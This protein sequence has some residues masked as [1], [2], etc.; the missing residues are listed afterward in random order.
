MAIVQLDTWAA[1]QV[2]TQLPQAKEDDWVEI[3]AFTDSD[4]LRQALEKFNKRTT[5]EGEEKGSAL[6]MGQK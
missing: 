3:N 6:D 4:D 5:P 1:A 2:Q